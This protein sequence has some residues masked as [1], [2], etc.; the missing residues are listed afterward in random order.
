MCI[1]TSAKVAKMAYG[2]LGA[3]SSLCAQSFVDTQD[4]ERHEMDSSKLE[5]NGVEVVEFPVWPLVGNTNN[6]N[7]RMACVFWH[8]TRRAIVV[9]VR[10]D[11][12]V[13]KC[14][15]C[16]PTSNKLESLRN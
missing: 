10:T 6:I 9:V 2:Q 7:A 15:L 1:E 3:N 14:P 13:C 5:T 16:N 12:T 8:K 4:P 11:S